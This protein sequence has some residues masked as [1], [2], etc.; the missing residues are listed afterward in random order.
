MKDEVSRLIFEKVI[1]LFKP[2]LLAFEMLNLSFNLNSRIF[3]RR[4]SRSLKKI[5]L[6][7]KLLHLQKKT[8]IKY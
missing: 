3:F 4:L 7:L 5:M 8:T 1:L 2:F 6:V